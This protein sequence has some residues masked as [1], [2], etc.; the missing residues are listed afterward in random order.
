MRFEGA[1]RIGSIVVLLI[2]ALGLAV[3]R[4]EPVPVEVVQ[5]SHDDPNLTAANESTEL[6]VESVSQIHAI[7]QGRF[8]PEWL[9]R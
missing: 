1:I 2:V 3:A 6:D 4:Q 5:I 9:Q 7:N 8:H